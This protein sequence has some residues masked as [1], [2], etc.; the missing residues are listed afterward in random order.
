MAGFE[1][2]D[3]WFLLLLFPLAGMIAFY[4]LKS[5]QHRGA[6][7][8]VSSETIVAR[9]RSFRVIAY[10]FLPALRFLSILFLIVALARPGRGVEYTSIKNL[11]IDIMVVLDASDSMMGEDFEPD[12]RLEVAKRVVR[13]FVRRR[14]SDRIGMVVFSGD[15][16]LQCPLTLEHRMIE[17]IIGDIDFETVEEE[18]TAI[19]EALALAASRMTDSHAKGKM[20][21]LLTDGVNNRGSIDPETAARMCAQ[22][23]IRVYTV[24]IGREGMVP[25]PGGRGIFGFK[26]YERNQFDEA[27][28]RKISEIT[29]GRFYRAASSGVLW[30]NVKEIDRLE[31]SEVEMKVYRDFFDRFGVFLL[32][33]MAIFFI[34][35]FLRSVVLRK[36]P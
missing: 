10:R 5:L 1:F 13:D 15:A 33:S 34:E 18:G 12:N 16:Y 35:I 36:I 3:P 21:L 19:G 20:V 31:K 22:A 14:K 9:H 28:L 23:G 11:G 17:D 25:Y 27:A 24:G 6:A 32:L 7:I 8:A 4:Y 30:E 2:K 26:R 29:D